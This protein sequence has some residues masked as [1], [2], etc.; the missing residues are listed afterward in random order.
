MYYKK[1]PLVRTTDARRQF[2]LRR[3]N[4][5]KAE[6]DNEDTKTKELIAKQ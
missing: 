1:K 5:I 2:L 4:E 6:L 3:Y